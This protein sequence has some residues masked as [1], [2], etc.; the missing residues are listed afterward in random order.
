MDINLRR[1]LSPLLDPDTMSRIEEWAKY[2]EEV[3]LG[4]L[5]SATDLATI[6]RAQ[7]Q[8]QE[9]RALMKMRDFIITKSE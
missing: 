3:A 9:A 1:R 5:V 6:H 8:V 2:R 7:G 4:I